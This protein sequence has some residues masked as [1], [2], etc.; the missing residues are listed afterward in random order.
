MST[1]NKLNYLIGTKNLIRTAIEDKG[2]TIEDTD[3]FR[4]YAEKINAIS[5]SA[6]LGYA[7]AAWANNTPSSRTLT[8]P[9]MST[10][11]VVICTSLREGNQ[12]TQTCTASVGSVSQLTSF[13]NNAGYNAGTYWKTTMWKVTKTAG[14]ASTITV[15][16]ENPYGHVGAHIEMVYN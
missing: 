12:D 6:S 13:Q 7:V 4:S 15:K 5:T 8:M 14:K 16:V 1:E 11:A 2:Q 3:T 9:D 10:E